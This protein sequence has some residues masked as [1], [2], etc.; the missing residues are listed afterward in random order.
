V[1]FEISPNEGRGIMKT[2]VI[3]LTFAAVLLL[4]GLAAAEV[5]QYKLP[6]PGVV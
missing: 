5:V 3:L 4:A 6:V 2:R 1:V